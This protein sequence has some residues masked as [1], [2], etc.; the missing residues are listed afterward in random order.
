[1]CDPMAKSDADANSI[2]SKTGAKSRSSRRSSRG[3]SRRSSKVSSRKRQQEDKAAA[4][5]QPI[6]Q[7]FF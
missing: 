6:C 3:S 5:P 7:C 2:N 1:M 4:E